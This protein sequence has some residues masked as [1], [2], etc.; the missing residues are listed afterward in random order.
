MNPNTPDKGRVERDKRRERLR[1]RSSD[2][3]TIKR[4]FASIHQGVIERT[5]LR[6]SIRNIWRAGEATGRK[7]CRDVGEGAAANIL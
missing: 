4:V 7:T 2:D 5:E 1:S 3:V 6:H